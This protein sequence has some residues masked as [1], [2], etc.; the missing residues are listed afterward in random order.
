MRYN[1]SRE[2]HAP[3]HLRDAF[4]E[5]VFMDDDR[6]PT[7][8]EKAT[9]FVKPHDGR[10]LSP[11]SLL[12]HLWNCTDIMPSVLRG[13]IGLSAG[14]AFAQGV[15]EIEYSLQDRR[16]MKS[17]VPSLDSRLVAA[18]AWDRYSNGLSRRG[19]AQG[20]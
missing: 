6:A 18:S 13:V 12:G 10:S 5:R 16:A 4:F 8:D 11:Q 14:S 20:L 7:L 15:L 1:L 17:P 3:G 9:E 2:C 19:K